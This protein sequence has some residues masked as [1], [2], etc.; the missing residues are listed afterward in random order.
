MAGKL[1][2]FAP[3]KGGV[4]KTTMATEC[5]VRALLNG[6][7]TILIDSDPQQH[8][9]SWGACRAEKE[10][11]GMRIPQL[12]V[13]AATRAP[14]TATKAALHQHLATL[15]RAADAYDLVFVDLGG[16]DS[17]ELRATVQV[18]NLVVV[19]II[20][21]NFN[22]W[23]YERLY[24]SLEE[25]RTLNPS[26]RVLGVLN[27]LSTH[28]VGGP[29][30]EAEARG[31]LAESFV[32]EEGYRLADA[33]LR[34]RTVYRRH[35]EDGLCLGELSGN[36]FDSKADAEAQAVFKETLSYAQSP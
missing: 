31:A 24:N 9:L 25:S 21:S 11:E 29:R 17:F 5:S 8:A 28:S 2:A 6:Y 27:M 16:A 13:A 1:L 22:G 12:P 15:R 14:G 7:S 3:S 10:A 35:R 32:E 26:V 4:G 33:G 20:P 19:P 30:E 23:G 34:A 18:A 36:A